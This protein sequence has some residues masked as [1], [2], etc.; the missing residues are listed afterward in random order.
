LFERLAE[1]ESRGHT[2]LEI[3]IGTGAN[4]A[5]RGDGGMWFWFG[6]WADVGRGSGQFY[7]AGTSVVG[8]DPNPYM[9]VSSRVRRWRMGESHCWC[10]IF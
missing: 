8:V 6:E 2:V 9:R 7:P 5:V 3:G 10:R 1:D 4:F